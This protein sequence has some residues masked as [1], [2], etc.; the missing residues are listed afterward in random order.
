MGCQEFEQSLEEDLV[1]L[2]YL[3][4]MHRGMSFQNQLTYF[5]FKL[6]FYSVQGLNYDLHRNGW[7]T[8]CD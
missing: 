3:I 5:C 4:P 2:A 6:G 1:V 7:I 8:L